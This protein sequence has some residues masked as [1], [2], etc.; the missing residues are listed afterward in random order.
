MRTFAILALLLL[1]ESVCAHHS[2]AHYSH[3]VRELD[4]ELVAVHWV[5][6]HVGITLK[7]LTE[8]GD[9]ELWR[10]EGVSNLG[11]MRKAGVPGD[12]LTVGERITAVGSVS[13]RR[14]RD[15]LATNL[16]L[17]DG[18]EIVLDEDA[19]P[20]WAG[21][22]TIGRPDPASIDITP[23][24]DSIIAFVTSSQAAL[25]CSSFGGLTLQR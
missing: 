21:G 25:N 18:T 15:L 3:D 23:V 2:R 19:G 10:V 24:D 14:E 13:L 17:E 4:G 11:G 12:R 7:V 1:A 5:N 6:P 16:L 9:E 20:H 8:A 22:R